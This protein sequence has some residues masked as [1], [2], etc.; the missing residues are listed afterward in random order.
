MLFPSTTQSGA[1]SADD[2]MLIWIGTTPEMR[3]SPRISRSEQMLSVKN[4]E[5]YLSY[6]E[7]LEGDWFVHSVN[8]SWDFELITIVNLLKSPWEYRILY[9]PVELE[10]ELYMDWNKTDEINFLRLAFWTKEAVKKAL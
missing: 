3:W 9:N 6:K 5:S 8:W 1:Q 4:Y 7:E 2:F 10:F